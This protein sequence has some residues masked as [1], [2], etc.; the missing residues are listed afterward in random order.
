MT[1]TTTLKVA[2]LF[3]EQGVLENAH[4][5]FNENI[6]SFDTTDI[7]ADDNAKDNNAEEGFSDYWL[8]PGLID[9]HAH[10][11]MGAD[12]MDATHESLA[13]M[14]QYYASIGVVGFLPTT[15]TAPKEDICAA[16]RQIHASKKHGVPGAKI[17]GGYLEGPFFNAIYKGAQPEEHF[18]SINRPELDEFIEAAQGSLVSIALAPEQPSALELIPYL[19]QQGIRVMLGHTNADFEQTT[20][21]LNA[22]ADGVVHCFNGMRGLHHREPGVVG[23]ALACPHCYT[24]LIAD[25]EHVHKAILKFCYQ[26]KGSEYVNLITDSVPSSGLEDGQYFLG[27]VPVTIKDGV[28]RTLQGGLAGST[29]KLLKAVQNT[30]LWFDIDL[31]E[32][33]KMASLTPATML[34]LEQKCGSIKT[35]KQA[36]FTLIDKDFNVQATWVQGSIVYRK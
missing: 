16:L 12:V 20:A 35:G 9:T 3:T 17:L 30:A 19:K 27:E 31:Q 2:R 15:M 21:A 33:L 18:L 8:I 32:A 34:G 26:L 14:S 10:G 23:A 28:A 4:I 36:N 24:E 25:G 1:K 7:S 29:L 6:L 5:T 22:G 11:A 13:T